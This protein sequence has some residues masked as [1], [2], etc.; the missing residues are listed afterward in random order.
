MFFLLQIFADETTSQA[1]KQTVHKSTDILSRIS[2]TLFNT[3]SL[4]T[5]VVVLIIAFILGRIA[6]A[7]IRHITSIIGERINKTQN[8]DV[9]TKLRRTET[10]LVLSIALLR[11]A[12][13][14]AALY[15]WWQFTHPGR[16]PTGILGASAVAA[17]IASAM[18]TPVLRDMAYGAV[19]MAEHWYGV[20]DYISIDPYVKG[21]GVVER[22]TLRSTKIRDIN[23]EVIW[24]HNQ[25]LW[26]V[27]VSPR[28]VRTVAVELFVNNLEKTVKL[29]EEANTRT[30]IDPL[31][32]ITP[33]T[34]MKQQQTG[35]N[36]WQVTVIAEVVPGR[37]WLLD[38][39][40][41][42]VIKELNERYKVLVNEPFTRY[43]DA[44]SERRFGETI[45]NSRKARTRRHQSIHRAAQQSK[46]AKKQQNKA[47]DTTSKKS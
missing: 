27:H 3:R 45:Q 31:M 7:I 47:A 25:S 24:V 36:T 38:N 26:S 42:H 32:V 21:Q 19:M 20:G 28:G 37:E 29:I 39:L 30:P 12:F 4:V 6:A 34:V 15:F 10:F 41:I 44:E 2:H 11:I 46:E 35:E 40:A 33:M 1:V 13:F 5:L 22:L 23:G 18:L 16:I 8:L 43:T 9:V 14:V 17:L